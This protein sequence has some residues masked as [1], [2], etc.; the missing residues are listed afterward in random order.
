MCCRQRELL[1]YPICGLVKSIWYFWSFSVPAMTQ[2][3]WL[4]LQF[5]WM[6]SGLSIPQTAVCDFRKQLFCISAIN[7]RGPARFN[8]R[9][10]LG[11]S[12]YINNIISNTTNLTNAHLYTDDTALYCTSNTTHSSTEILQQAFD[13]LQHSLF[14]LKSILN[15]DKTKYMIFSRAKNIVDDVLHIAT[16][17]VLT[18]FQ[19]TNIWVSGSIRNLHLNFILTYKIGCLYRNKLNSPLLC[20]KQIT[21]A[22]FLS[23]L[24]YGDV[25]H[26]HASASSLIP[27]DSVYHSDDDDDDDD[28]ILSYRQG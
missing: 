5:S 16:M 1:C 26:R 10:C 11:Y 25:L 18:G 17:T 23:A 28:D 4:L 27:L 20:R 6:V 9:S 12:Y 15:A 7:K 13:N 21:E 24:D 3:Y 19:N 14:D 8:T 2:G 22:V